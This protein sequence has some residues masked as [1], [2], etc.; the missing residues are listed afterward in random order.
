MSRR[1]V[2]L[3]VVVPL[4]LWLSCTLF[5]GALYLSLR[6]PGLRPNVDEFDLA[7]EGSEMAPS[8]VTLEEGDTAYLRMTT[9]HPVEFRIAGMG[10]EGALEP[11][12][13]RFDAV[14]G[15]KADRVGHFDIED[16]RTRT[17][18]GVFVVTPD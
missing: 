17:K 7:I 1:W 15:V 3:L 12:G 10:F 2:V 14:W 5:L 9:D 4:A 16:G 11:Q 6:Y 13:S 18:L 8:K